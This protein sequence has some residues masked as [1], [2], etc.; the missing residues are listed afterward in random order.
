[1]QYSVINSN[2]FFYR[3]SV[4]E[5]GFIFYGTS[6]KMPPAL[7]KLLLTFSKLM[8]FCKPIKCL[9]VTI[10]DVSFLYKTLVRSTAL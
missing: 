10:N 5:S 9:S 1:M 2:I 8:Q 7:P 3:T 6:V 4:H